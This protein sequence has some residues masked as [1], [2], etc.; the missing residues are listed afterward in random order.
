MII[1]FCSYHKIQKN[2][3]VHFN[4]IYKLSKLEV[5]NVHMKNIEF[6]A[7]QLFFNIVPYS[8]LCSIFMLCLWYIFT[9]CLPTLYYY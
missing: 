9:A 3:Y 6:F 5:F 1:K 8:F 4:N 7:T 2:V